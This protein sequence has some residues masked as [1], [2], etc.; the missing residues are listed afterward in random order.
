MTRARLA[1][2]GL[3][4]ASATT[5]AE[6][7]PRDWKPWASAPPGCAIWVPERAQLA[8]LEEL[9]W[10]R[11]PFQREGCEA[12]GATWAARTGWGFGGR[13]SAA[14]DGKR[15]YVA[16]TRA[17]DAGDRGASKAAR[18]AAP[19]DSASRV[20][21]QLWETVVLEDDGARRVPVAAF[22]QRVPG[23]G[24]VLGSVSLR[25]TGNAVTAAVP[26]LREDAESAPVVVIAAP[27]MLADRP[28][29]VERFG[30]PDAVLAREVALRGGDLL[31]VWE[32]EGRFA[33][34]DLATGA[35]RRPVP[36]AP[37]RA[38][39]EPTPIDGGV[40]Y[41]LWTGDRGSVWLAD[42]AGKS[43]PVLADPADSYD[44]FA[45]DGRDAVWTRARGFVELNTF[46]TVELWAGRMVDGAVAAPRRVASLAGGA[47]PLVSIGDGWA[48][49][50]TSGSE[51]QLVRIADGQVRRLPAVPMLSWDGGSGGLVIAG[52]A[53]W[54]RASLRGGPGNDIRLIA[55][56][57]LDALPGSR[58]EP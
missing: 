16:L 12:L 44:R 3:A 47:L 32:H 42:R 20:D 55:R 11:C 14:S 46:Q 30:G 53:V 23:A 24:C 28:E 9:A 38:L 40:V 52:G 22:R 43:R 21:A 29:R 58:G 10:R 36:P 37:F 34:R 49:L 18:G 25:R 19:G 2:V 31:A 5:A 41:A 54:A 33:I 27:A 48:A 1:L 57:A 26:I 45:T 56:F 4:L 6:P 51:V 8:K 17:V 7:A 35:T 13:L 50:W 39:L 15:T